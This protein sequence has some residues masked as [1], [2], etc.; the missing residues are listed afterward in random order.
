[1]WIICK[2][3]HPI[4]KTRTNSKTEAW[5]SFNQ[6]T[7]KWERP[8]NLELKL[9]GLLRALPFPQLSYLLPFPFTPTTTMLCKEEKK[10]GKAMNTNPDRPQGLLRA[11]SRQFRQ[12][13]LLL[14]LPHV[15][16]SKPLP[17]HW[18]YVMTPSRHCALNFS[19][20]DCFRYPY[21]HSN[22]MDTPER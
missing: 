17:S 5:L 20:W 3:N 9:L 10:G 15:F 6:S 21:L 13:C 7:V 2:H 22:M 16:S 4:I 11:V 1:M 18:G 8:E 14:A 19:I 12:N